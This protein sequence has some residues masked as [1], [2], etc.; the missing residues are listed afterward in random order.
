MSK[1]TSLSLLYEL[2]KSFG[3]ESEHAAQVVLLFHVL[4]MNY[5]GMESLFVLFGIR[6][7]RSHVLELFEICVPYADSFSVMPL[8]GRCKL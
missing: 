6:D 7:V 2:V 5:Q 4:K 3:Q 1:R 8:G